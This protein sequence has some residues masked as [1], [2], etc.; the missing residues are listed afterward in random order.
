VPD[1]A[2]SLTRAQARVAAVFLDTCRVDRDLPGVDDDELDEETG[3]LVP[4]AD[5]DSTIYTGACAVLVDTDRVAQAAGSDMGQQPYPDRD[6]H[7]SALLPVTAPHLLAGD[8]LTIL[9]SQRDAQLVGRRFRVI[10][11]GPVTTFAV[12]RKV[13]LDVAR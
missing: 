11:D 7:Y 8:E 10:K 5:D 13:P 9:T 1:L 12:V 6:P 3:L 4:P 2:R